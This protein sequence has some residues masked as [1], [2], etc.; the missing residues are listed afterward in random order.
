MER[1]KIFLQTDAPQSS[2]Q[3][4]KY[5]TLALSEVPGKD[6]PYLFTHKRPLLLSH[7]SLY[8]ATR[9]NNW[10]AEAGWT[11]RDFVRAGE[12]PQQSPEAFVSL[13]Q[14]KD[15]TSSMDAN[16]H[17][18]WGSS[19]KENG[20]SCGSAMFVPENRTDRLQKKEPDGNVINCRKPD[21]IYI[22]RVISADWLTDRWRV[23]C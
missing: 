9:K 18:N 20:R 14:I 16:G 15:I 4:N 6:V 10:E 21:L 11:L 1:R 23:V 7:M 3:D 17:L 22:M 2:W 13:D 5:F 19:L 12:E 8:S